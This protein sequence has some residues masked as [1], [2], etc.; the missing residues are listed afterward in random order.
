MAGAL[1]LMAGAS[2][3]L[4]AA[5]VAARPA[6]LDPGAVVAIAAGLVV[7]GVVAAAGILADRGSGWWLPLGAVV[8]F[9]SLW[10]VHAGFDA[11]G[12]AA[13]VTGV[14]TVVA[15]V[16]AGRG[17]R[18]RA[19]SVPPSAAATALLLVPW[20]LAVG[21][22]GGDDFGVVAAAIASAGWLLLLLYT[23]AAPG[24]WLLV[25]VLVPAFGVVMG[26]TAPWP[27]AAFAVLPAAA[28]TIAALA[29]TSRRAVKP[30]ITRGEAFPIPPELAPRS[31]LR[32]AGR[33]EGE[34]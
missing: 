22:A 9:D 26:A 20:P 29:P 3:L 6:D 25:R 23:Q 27:R 24:A 2:G 15:T 5:A 34:T 11:A 31:V 8:G 21:L 28:I 30:R 13:A 4:G 33:G 19:G 14:A 12:T 16:A 1:A 18:R 10:P 7:G 17:R 32:E